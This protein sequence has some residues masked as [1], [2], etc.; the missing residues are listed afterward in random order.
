MNNG[1]VLDKKKRKIA[2]S[3]MAQEFSAF[4]EVFGH[5]C[6]VSFIFDDLVCC[7]ECFGDLFPG[8]PN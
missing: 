5:Q 3:T 7:F 1:F 6:S 8:K 4:T 2:Q